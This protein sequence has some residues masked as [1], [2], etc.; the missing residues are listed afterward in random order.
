MT[1]ESRVRLTRGQRRV[2]ELL[3]DAEDRD[4]DADLVYEQA[5]AGG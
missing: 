2:L 1:T 4:V 3:R 5:V